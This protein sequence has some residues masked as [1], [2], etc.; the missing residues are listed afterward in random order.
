MM[1]CFSRCNMEKGIGSVMRRTFKS[2]CSQ[3][4]DRVAAKFEEGFSGSMDSVRVYYHVNWT[5]VMS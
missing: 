5:L 1:T 4:S 3:F 2:M